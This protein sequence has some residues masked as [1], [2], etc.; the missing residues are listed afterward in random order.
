MNKIGPI[1]KRGNIRA[2]AAE[3][4]NDGAYSIKNTRRL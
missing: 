3:I 1:F 2:W 4:S